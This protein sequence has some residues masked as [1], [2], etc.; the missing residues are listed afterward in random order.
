MEL[1]VLA[2]GVGGGR[3]CD[4][5]E[6]FLPPSDHLTVVANVGDDLHWCGLRVCPDFDTILYSMSGKADLAKGWGVADERWTAFETLR[7]LGGPGWFQMGDRDLGLQLFRAELLSGSHRLSE[8]CLKLCRSFGLSADVIPSSDQMIPTLVQI[9]SGWISFQSYFVERRHADRIL[10]LEF[11]GAKQTVLT[12]ELLA[13]WSKAEQILLA[14]SNPFVSIDP[15]LEVA[16][17]R[18]RLRAFKGVRVAVSPLIGS[19]AIKG[20]AADMMTAFG[21]P[22]NS[23]GV[24]LHYRGLIDAIVIDESDQQLEGP[25]RELGLQ[26]LC[27][28]TLMKDRVD[29][30]RLAGQVLDWTRQSLISA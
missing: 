13:G 7:E 30:Q 10:G 4:G 22:C 5:L 26:V 8:V 2:G 18:E 24:A 6:Q 25:L 1:M 12:P 16:D 14:P 15:I 9:E 17:Q 3:F 28:P 19:S 20:P 11:R 23:L 27:C 29:R 21:Y